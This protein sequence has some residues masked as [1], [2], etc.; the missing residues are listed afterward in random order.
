MFPSFI[1][2]ENYSA[3]V[4]N[5]TKHCTKDTSYSW[6]VNVFKANQCEPICIFPRITE[7]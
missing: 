1:N 6:G 3:E 5:I 4:I 2:V 7:H